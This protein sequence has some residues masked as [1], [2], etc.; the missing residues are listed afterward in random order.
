MQAMST[1]AALLIAPAGPAELVAGARLLRDALGFQL[2]D[3]I[4]PWLMQ[5]AVENGG[6]ALAARD[7]EDLL[8]FSFGMAAVDAGGAPFLYSCGLAVDPAHRGRGVG[9]A[10][11]LAQRRAAASLGHASVRWTADPL[12]AAALRLYL[13]GLGATLT[14][15]RAALHDAVRASSR[16]PQDDVTIEWS[17]DPRVRSAAGPGFVVELPWDAASLPEPRWLACR[18]DVRAAVRAH[19]ARGRVGTAVEVDRAAHRCFLVF[20]PRDA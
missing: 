4:P 7:G 6:V 5:T 16:K 3:G 15:Y 2:E 18:H 13:T 9:R 17:V 20:T 12:N 11:K 14:G 10:L 1:T 8:G 19:L